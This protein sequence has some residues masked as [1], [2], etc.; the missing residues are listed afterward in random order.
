M[1]EHLSRK[2]IIAAARRTDG[3]FSAHLQN[4]P[5]CRREVELFREYFMAGRAPLTNAPQA[6]IEKAVMIPD[7][8]SRIRAAAEKLV[9]LVFDSWAAPQPIGVRG[10]QSVDERRLRFR[11]DDMFLDLRGEK[12]SRGWNFIAELLAAEI[13]FVQIEFKAN[14]KIITADQTGLFQW[15][16][17]SAPRKIT[18]RV[19]DHEYIF[20]ELTWKRPS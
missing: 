18:L 20:P 5:E 3:K 12:H 13:S 1:D 2:E 10:E 15:S 14:D 17:K 7:S 16:S 4:C 19:Q 6:L 8:G 9:S 11:I